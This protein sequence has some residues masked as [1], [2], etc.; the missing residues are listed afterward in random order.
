MATTN[1]SNDR[2]VNSSESLVVCHQIF[3]QDLVPCIPVTLM[4]EQIE[5]WRGPNHEPVGNGTFLSARES[6]ENS[7]KNLVWDS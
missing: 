7:I 6:V 2:L 3:Y 4:K 1:F 5:V